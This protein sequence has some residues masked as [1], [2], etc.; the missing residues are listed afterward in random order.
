MKKIRTILLLLAISGLLMACA[1]PWQARSTAGYVSG[2]ALA[3]T[4]ESAVKPSC[5]AVAIPADRCGQLKDIYGSI[6]AGLVSAGNTLILAFSVKFIVLLT[7]A[8]QC[9]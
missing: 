9:F 2:T 1:T 4:A 8:S 7:A 3:G 5:D 6:R